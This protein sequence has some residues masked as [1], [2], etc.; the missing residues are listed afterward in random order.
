MIRRAVLWLSLTANKPLLK[1]DDDD[2]RSQNLHQLLA[3]ARAA[4]AV[5]HRVFRMQMDT[6]KPS[7]RQRATAGDLL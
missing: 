1:L 6:I 7:R 2:F 4:R 3:L 5:C